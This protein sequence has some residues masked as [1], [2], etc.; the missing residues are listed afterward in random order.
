MKCV[1]CNSM[2]IVNN[3]YYKSYQKYK[4]KDC[5][6]QF[7]ERSFSFFSRHRFPEHVI[8]NSILYGFFV[9]TRNT[10]FLAKETM[11]VIFSHQTSYNWN[12]KFAY[13]VSK[14]TKVTNFSNIWHVDEKFIKCRNKKDKNGKVK[15]SYLWVVIDS[16][17]NIIATHVSHERNMKNARIVLRK[18][19]LRAVKPPDILVSDGLQ[20]Y[21]K[22]CKKVFGRKTKHILAH[23][24]TKGF[25]HKGKLYYLSNNRIESLNSKINLWYK[26]S[27]G[28]KSLETAKLWCEMFNY[29]YNHMRPRVIKHKTITIQEVIVSC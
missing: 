17:N 16:N 9:S 4:C 20:A 1:T 7:T 2:N 8:K 22:A 25:M 28:F 5:D 23:F 21:K 3:G 27:R 19:K 13:L 11:D 6:R 26:K 24:E 29:F 12:K 10:S 15:F 18:A 14:L